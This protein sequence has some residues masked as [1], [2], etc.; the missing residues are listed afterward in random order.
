MLMYITTQTG[1][2]WWDMGMD[3]VQSA[4]QPVADLEIWSIGGT[5]VHLYIV[6]SAGNN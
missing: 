1:R 3:M 5:S 6:D 2:E 4:I